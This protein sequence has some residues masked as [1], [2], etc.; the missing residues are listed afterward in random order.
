MKGWC[1]D[2]WQAESFPLNCRHHCKRHHN[3][4]TQRDLVFI[5]A[6]QIDGNKGMVGVRRIKARKK[7]GRGS[8]ETDGFEMSLSLEINSKALSKECVVFKQAFF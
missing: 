7:G 1:K 3:T 2:K 4:A 6:Q 8:S 5:F